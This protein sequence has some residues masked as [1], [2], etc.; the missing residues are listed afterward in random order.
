MN[1][2][3]SKTARKD[4]MVAAILEKTELPRMCRVR[5]SF[6]DTHIAQLE[7]EVRRQLKRPGTLDRVR[8]G[9][10]IAVTAGSRGVADIA[11]ILRTVVDEIRCVGGHPFVIPAMGSHGGAVATGQLGI[12]RGYGITEE[13]MGC[14]IRAT[15]DT[16]QIGSAGN[17]M[18]VRID[19][20][21]AEADGIVV[22]GRI[23]SHTSFHGSHE[24]GLMKMVTIG[25]GKQY[26]AEICHEQGF[27]KMERNI[28][29]IARETIASGRILFGLGIIE[30]AYNQTKQL[31]SVP[32][33]LIEAEE[34]GLL[35][36]AKACKASLLVKDIDVLVVDE[37]GKN[38]SGEGMD[39]N[40]TGRWSTPFASGGPEIQRIALLDLTDASHGN[41]GGFGMADFSTQRAFDKMDFDQTY[42][43]ILTPT[44]IRPGMIPIIMANDELAIK[45]AVQTCNGIDKENPRVIRIRN[46]KKIDEILISEALVEEVLG[47]PGME[48]LGE[49]AFMQFDGDGNLV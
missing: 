42:P 46:T 5:Q 11:R 34:P 15:M 38:I 36:E 12:L 29:S 14:P 45:A 10:S 47:T 43:N 33:E 23:A 28:V 41:A 13:S 21:A 6:D 18:P 39:P 22:V 26:G 32:A 9:Q 31:A 16:V 27:G 25:L 37:A 48:M 1:Q 2:N 17:G 8:P 19:A 24:S 30:N 4:G 44:V 20:N 40:V 3:G 7:D 49:P 35:K